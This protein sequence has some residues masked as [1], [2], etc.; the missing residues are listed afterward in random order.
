[1]V[2]PAAVADTQAVKRIALLSLLLVAATAGASSAGAV[3]AGPRISGR[4]P[5][6][7]LLVAGERD[8]ILVGLDGYARGRIVGVRPPWAARAILLACMERQG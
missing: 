6:Q 4:L 5:A 7:A 2:G 1:M 8:T 3:Q